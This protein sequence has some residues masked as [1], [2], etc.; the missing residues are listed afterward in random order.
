MLNMKYAGSKTSY[1]VEFRK[2][3]PRVVELRGDFPA[4]D[5]GFT[6][7]RDE[8]DDAWDYKRFKTIYRKIDG[9]VQ[10]SDDGSVY[11]APPSRSPSPLPS[12]SRSPLPSLNPMYRHSTK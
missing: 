2:V 12:P 3:S 9:G 6:L 7:S 1:D 5:K 10:F 11:V 8:S 4:K